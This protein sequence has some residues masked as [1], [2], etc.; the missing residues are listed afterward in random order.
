MK[1]YTTR[2]VCVNRWAD[3]EKMVASSMRPR[4][5]RRNYSRAHYQ[6]VSPPADTQAEI[7]ARLIDNRARE[8]GLADRR[9]RFP[10]LAAENAQAA[11]DYQEERIAFHRSKLSSGQAP[12]WGRP[13]ADVGHLVKCYIAWHPDRPEEV[14]LVDRVIDRIVE[15]GESVWHAAAQ[16][17][18]HKCQCSPCCQARGDQPVRI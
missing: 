5:G 13:R 1:A 18:G 16:V 9:T 8:L 3:R 7:Q 4:Y 10:E 17:A 11:I 15:T 12:N 14:A 2:P 6:R